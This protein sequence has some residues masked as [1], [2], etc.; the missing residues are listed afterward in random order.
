LNTR[1]GR[2][3]TRAVA[4]FPIAIVELDDDEPHA[5]GLARLQAEQMGSKEKFWLESVGTAEKYLLKFAR[6]G[7]G[8]DWA[9]KL[10]SEF[11]RIAGLDLP[12]A[13][14]ELATYQ[15]R[16]AVLVRDFLRGGER[17][18]PGNE[19]LVERDPE[20]PTAQNYRVRAHTLSAVFEVLGTKRIGLPKGDFPS[21]VKTP[22]D[23]FCGYLALDALIG[24]TDRHHENW[25]IVVR[26]EGPDRVLSLAPTYD[27]GSSLGREL[28]DEHR[29][30]R[31]RALDHRADL[32]AYA[33]RAR[34]AVYARTGDAKPLTTFGAVRL[35]AEACPQAMSAWLK[36]IRE[37]LGKATYLELI[38][39]VPP[40]VM[41]Q[42]AKDFV[43]RL[44]EYN[45]AKL[46]E[47]TP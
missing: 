20:Y 3:Y 35:A 29:D 46:I 13:E 41:S 11:A 44:V 30:R 33:S 15:S 36:R 47:Y 5:G 31:L 19:L 8:E 6:D 25:G 16:R 37:S 12:C 42:V 34:S 27:H 43:S 45:L 9:E 7:T 4:D 28:S 21:E 1:A 17:L 32:A 22:I 14:V 10:A 18:I 2:A 26:R 39:R 23:L 40:T 38:G 24:N